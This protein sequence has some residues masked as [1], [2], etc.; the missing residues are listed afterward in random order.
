MRKVSQSHHPT[1]S[2]LSGL[3]TASL[4]FGVLGLTC[5]GPLGGLAA[6]LCGHAARNRWREE[7][8]PRP[9]SGGLV[10]GYLSL[11]IYATAGAGWLVSRTYPARA[12]R[13][14]AERAA[15]CAANLAV[16][17]SA[18]EAAAFALNLADNAVVTPEQ[19]SP[20][21]GGGFASLSCPAGGTYRIGP[22][23]TPPSCSM[24][25]GPAETGGPD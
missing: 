10:L 24:H 12:E 22:V 3:A 4:T 5:L 19:L 17:E 18:K 13:R 7:G 20:Y 6:V 9:G 15:A 1:G 23:G 16:I 8:S 14:D 21:I 25:R 11:L 2:G